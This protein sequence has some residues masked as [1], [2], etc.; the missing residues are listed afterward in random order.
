MPFARLIGLIGPGL[1]DVDLF[2]VVSGSPFV[3]T[4]SNL[5]GVGGAVWSVV[6]CFARLLRAACSAKSTSARVTRAWRGVA[7]HTTNFVP[8]IKLWCGKLI[9][10]PNAQAHLPSDPRSLSRNGV[11][12]EEEIMALEQL[13]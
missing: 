5:L 8:C 3:Q 12:A 4:P 10:E 11:S 2:G 6:S 13:Q 9:A 7:W 1:M